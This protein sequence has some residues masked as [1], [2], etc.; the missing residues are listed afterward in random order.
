MKNLNYGKIFADLKINSI[1]EFDEYLDKMHILLS[2]EHTY[3]TFYFRNTF[4]LENF[5]ENSKNNYFQE[6]DTTFYDYAYDFLIKY[7]PILIESFKE[8]VPTI[9][10]LCDDEY[11]QSF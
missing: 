8:E 4:N 7:H 5:I 6:N 3:N 11:S 9:E 10:Q 1:K 2:N